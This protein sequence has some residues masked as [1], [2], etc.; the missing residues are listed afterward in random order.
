MLQLLDLVKVM[1][2]SFADLLDKQ[3]SIRDLKLHL[4]LDLVV[5]LCGIGHLL[6][7]DGLAHLSSALQA[8]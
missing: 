6:G 3:W 5:A 7:S 1:D 8:G 2:E 4:L